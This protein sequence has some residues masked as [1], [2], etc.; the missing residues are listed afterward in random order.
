MPSTRKRLASGQ[1]TSTTLTSVYTA[2]SATRT[3][4][5][6]FT[7]TNTTTSEVLCSVY[8]NDGTDRLIQQRS[9]PGGVG[10]QLEI[11]ISGQT[12]E[13]G[14]ILKL[15]LD[16]ASSVDHYISGIEVT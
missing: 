9:C 2:P 5:S 13:E 1:L 6:R 10:K 3:T 8:I 11:D 14:Y 15:Q 4:L 16:T 12:L 7:I